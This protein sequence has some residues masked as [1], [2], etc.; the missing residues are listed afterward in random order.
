MEHTGILTHTHTHHMLSLFPALR[1]SNHILSQ[2]HEESNGISTFTH[3]T[4]SNRVTECVNVCLLAKYSY[5]PDV[6]YGHF[7][8]YLHVISKSHIAVLDK[9]S[10]L[11]NQLFLKYILNVTK[12]KKQEALKPATVVQEKM[13][14]FPNKQ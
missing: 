5:F 13:S 1:M 14:H 7:F 8:R 4:Y 11:N 6:V 9:N 10:L 2:L 3:V 12:K